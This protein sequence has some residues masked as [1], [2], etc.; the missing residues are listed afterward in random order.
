MFVLV[1][2][3][4]VVTPLKIVSLFPGSRFREFTISLMVLGHVLVVDLVFVLVPLVIVTSVFI[5]V[6]LGPVGRVVV[7]VSPGCGRASQR[8][9]NKE[10]GQISMH[11][12]LP[13]LV[14]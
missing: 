14:C 11:V 3:W 2:V 5:V 9:A 8:C 10:Y 4:V 12:V 6:A 7:V 1:M 13:Q